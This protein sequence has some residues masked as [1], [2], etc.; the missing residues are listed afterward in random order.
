[1]RKRLTDTNPDAE[2]LAKLRSELEEAKLLRDNLEKE[3]QKL[4]TKLNETQFGSIDE[5]DVETMYNEQSKLDMYT[6]R[7]RSNDFTRFW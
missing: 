3:N 5:E 2:K 4:R 1:M 6:H 7:D